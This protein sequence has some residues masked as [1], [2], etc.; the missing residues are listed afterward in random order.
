MGVGSGV[1]FRGFVLLP[2]ASLCRSSTPS[3]PADRRS[4]VPLLLAVAALAAGCLHPFGATVKPVSLE[5]AAEPLLKLG[6][7]LD[8]KIPFPDGLQ[9]HGTVYFPAEPNGT[10]FPVIM[11]L[12][13]YY[14]NLG[15]DTDVYSAKYPPSLLY[16]HFLQHG[17]AIALVSV[18]GTGQS[19]GCFQVGGLQEQQ[20]ARAIVEWL[21]SQPWSNG[22]IGMAGVSYDGSTPWEA[23]ASGAP[24]LKAIV[25]GEGISD[26]YNYTF[27]EGVPVGNGPS[28]NTYYIPL[29]DWA[30][31]HPSGAPA[32][33]AWLQDQPTNACPSQAQVIA[34]EYQT[35]LD[36]A[37]GPF[38]DERDTQTKLGN[39]SAAIYI[40][41]GLA[42]WNVRPDEVQNVWPLIHT[43][44]HMMLGQ[45]LH[46]IPWENTL[47]PDWNLA[48]YNDTITQ[49]F[50][51]FL[52]GDRASE[53]AFNASPAVT[54]QDSSGRWWNFTAWPP[55]EAVPTPMYLGAGTLQAEAPNQTYTAA[56]RADPT[57]HTPASIGLGGDACFYLGIVARVPCD[58]PLGTQLT[59]LSPTLD[60]PLRLFGN[61]SV[62]L[63]VKTDQPGGTLSAVLYDVDAYGTQT[64]VVP[65]YLNL[66]E[67]T[68]RERAEAVPTNTFLNVTIDM[69]AAAHVFEPGHRM[70]V[71]ISGTT[72]DN[73]PARFAPTF[74]V[75]S[76][77][78]QASFF[79]APVLADRA[80]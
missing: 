3:A 73:T 13:P 61:P 76:S 7:L 16:A 2:R 45:W 70:L 26:M 69:Y 23:A 30:Y 58:L 32:A 22:N 54:A 71:V 18:R 47:N 66:M 52:K 51:A 25:P 39:T 56:F 64:Q 43:P 50:D 44:K 74:T 5:G 4:I 34:A 8:V 35:Y 37:H 27:F 62:H 80:P 9:A 55:P 15:S 48:S 14:G 17:Y 10:R 24:H 59:F 60:R 65:G 53:A 6:H 29:V 19:Q 21:A 28:F 77:S 78:G 79:D 1:A 68:N 67:R 63:T 36:G 40:V 49:F 41:Q 31:L 11:D 75:A 46:N 20:D 38:W 57:G 42:D 12:G 33:L 72:T